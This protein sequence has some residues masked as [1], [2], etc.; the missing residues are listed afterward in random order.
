MTGREAIQTIATVVISVAFVAGGVFVAKKLAGSKPALPKSTQGGAATIF[1]KTVKNGS[2][3]VAVNATGSLMA[4]NRVDIFSEVQGVMLPDGGKFKAGNRFSKGQS[5]VNIN[6]A[7]FKA[8][9]MSQR[10]NLLNLITS[11]LADIRL[12]FPDS[13]EKWNS[14]AKAFDVNTKVAELPAFASDQEKM[15]IS[16]RNILST[17]YSIN[18]AELVLAKYSLS[19]P[20][21]GVLTEAS[22]TPGTVIRPGQKLGSFIDPS[23]FEMETPVNASMMEFLKVGQKVTVS[24][25]DNSGKSWQ[26]KVTRINN[27]IDA[28][29][30][31]RNAYLQVS[32]EGLEEGM[33]LEASIAATEIDNAI[34][35]PRSVLMNDNLVFVTDG[36]TLQQQE[37]EPLYFTEKTVIVSG[38][39]DD[40]QVLTKMPPSAYPGMEVVISELEN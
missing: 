30:Q 11:A 25:T 10:S 38:L 18:N 29:T 16:G 13:F 23:V 2:I 22:V 19:A 3:P 40:S 36:K 31:T 14:Y 28:A 32:G 7:D 24:A 4:L 9:L 5:L 17:Y 34:E 39:K 15:F 26:G 12:D 6:A 27:I 1:T 8:N 33:F 21:N 37:V 35:L 20:F